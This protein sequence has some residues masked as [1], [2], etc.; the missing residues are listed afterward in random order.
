[1]R[2]IGRKKIYEAAEMVSRKNV[3]SYPSFDLDLLWFPM[4]SSIP[5]SSTQSQQTKQRAVTSTSEEA[6]WQQEVVSNTTVRRS[7]RL[8]NKAKV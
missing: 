1:V 4:I 7:A 3:I 6:P 5:I 2:G 8:T